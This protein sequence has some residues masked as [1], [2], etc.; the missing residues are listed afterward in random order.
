MA[1]IATLVVLQGLA[2]AEVAAAAD[3]P[4]SGATSAAA[5]AAAAAAAI[6]MSSEHDR[7]FHQDAI[8]HGGGPQRG[9]FHG[10]GSTRELLQWLRA[11]GGKASFEVGEVCP[12]CMRGALAT[13]DMKAGEIVAIIP[14]HL[15]VDLGPATQTA[16]EAA[17]EWARLMHFESGERGTL[18]GR[19]MGEPVRG[20]PSGAFKATWAPFL[21]SLPP[22]DEVL[23]PEMWDP[24]LIAAAQSPEIA[25]AVAKAK[26]AATAVWTDERLGSGAPRRWEAAGVRM[27][28]PAFSH[29]IACIS[30]RVWD[31]PS[32]AHGGEI[33]SH[34]LPAFDMMNCADQGLGGAGGEDGPNV[35]AH[36]PDE[37]GGFVLI[38]I[39]DIAKGEEVTTNY[40]QQHL[41]RPDLALLGYGFVPVREPPLLSSIDLPPG[42]ADGLSPPH[43]APSSPTLDPDYGIWN[44]AYTAQDELERLKSIMRGFPTTAAQDVH[45]LTV[46]PDWKMRAVI[47][48]RL[49]RKRALNSAIQTLSK[50]L[51]AQAAN[52]AL[53]TAL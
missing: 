35:E 37:E 4:A 24:E 8:Y 10:G 51:A 16:A 3:G 39:R 1:T 17:H 50:A 20:T 26:L 43:G 41:H 40:G 52:G 22:W 31:Q 23:S 46:Q 49:G 19:L 12:G 32:W 27:S 13:A 53:T 33:R 42:F 2:T 38:A 5:A 48:W 9:F 36:V 14:Q 11:N 45:L 44:G 28:L 25:A 18:W 34:L 47:E 7:I 6:N 29:I 21:A 30:T 15:V